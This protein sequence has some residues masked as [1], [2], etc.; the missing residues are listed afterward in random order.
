MNPEGPSSGEKRVMRG[1]SWFNNE[2]FVT[3]MS[4][5]WKDLATIATDELGFRC[6]RDAT[7]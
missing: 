2:S 6:A 3:S 1:G 4:M 5:R 7:P